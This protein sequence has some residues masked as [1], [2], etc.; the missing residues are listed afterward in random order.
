MHSSNGKLNNTMENRININISD[1][2]TKDEI[3]VKLEYDDDIKPDIKLEPMVKVE[4]ESGTK[5]A[6]GGRT[7]GNVGAM[8]G[9]S[10]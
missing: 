8:S 10:K 4:S 3:M 5:N 1:S 7:I 6:V 9:P 2:E